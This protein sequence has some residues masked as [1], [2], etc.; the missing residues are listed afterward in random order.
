MCSYRA[1]T[2]LSVHCQRGLEVEEYL[3]FSGCGIKDCVL[4]H[5][6]KGIQLG[7]GHFGIVCQGI[8]KLESKETMNVALKYLKEGATSYDRL[9]FLQEAA[10]M[11]QFRHPNVVT[12]YG[13]TNNNGYVSSS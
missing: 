9:K 1:D 6:R 2:I 12:L 11:A 5:F 8:W 7:S 3:I 10:A 4:L 13:V